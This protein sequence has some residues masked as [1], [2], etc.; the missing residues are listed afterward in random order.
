M[1]SDLSQESKTTKVEPTEELDFPISDESRSKKNSTSIP[2]LQEKDAPNNS[3]V[4]STSSVLNTVEND[5]AELSVN[6][7]KSMY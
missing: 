6:I 7:T 5:S 1:E 2:I 4:T 3:A